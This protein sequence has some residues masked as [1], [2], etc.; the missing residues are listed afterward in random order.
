M[1][2]VRVHLSYIISDW[3]RRCLEWF[4]D[5]A[6]GLELQW[7]ILYLHVTPDIWYSTCYQAM[8]SQSS[9]DILTCQE[10]S[11]PTRLICSLPPLPHLLFYMYMTFHEA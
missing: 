9:P 1:A 8:E 2:L 4:D 3:D 10:H 5:S 11:H 7:N 6:T